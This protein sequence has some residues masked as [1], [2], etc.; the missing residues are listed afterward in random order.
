RQAPRAA[1]PAPLPRIRTR[2]G[3]TA[4]SSTS[5]FALPHW[6]TARARRTMA[7][8]LLETPLSSFAWLTPVGA[9]ENSSLD[10]GQL[11]LTKRAISGKVR[12]RA[13]KGR[14]SDG[15]PPNLAVFSRRRRPHRT[16]PVTAEGGHMQ[17]VEAI[18]TEFLAT[19]DM[20]LDMPIPIGPGP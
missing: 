3:C 18:T 16:R 6:S 12:G 19:W 8:Q 11:R 1:R 20:V 15:T 5:A 13:M 10:R 17:T 9:L 2:R 4:P 7:R 14:V